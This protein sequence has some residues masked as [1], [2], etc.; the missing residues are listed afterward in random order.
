MRCILHHNELNLR[1]ES[2]DRYLM[3]IELID[4]DLQVGAE[5]EKKHMLK[6]R[7]SQRIENN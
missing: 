3:W 6:K 4:A 1:E 2:I 7:I 5:I